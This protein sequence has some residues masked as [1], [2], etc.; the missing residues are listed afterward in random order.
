MA[1]TNPTDD[2]EPLDLVKVPND[3]SLADEPLDLGW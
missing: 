3:T 1:A 2:Y